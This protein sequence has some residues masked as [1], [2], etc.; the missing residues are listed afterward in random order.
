VGAGVFEYGVTVIHTSVS[1]GETVD[2]GGLFDNSCDGKQSPWTA[3]DMKIG[4]AAVSGLI[5]VVVQNHFLNLQE[6][7]PEQ[8]ILD[9]HV[10]I[11]LRHLKLTVD[12]FCPSVLV[13]THAVDDQVLHPRVL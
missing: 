7:T 2:V 6:A 5:I 9:L 1:D 13:H 8:V 12:I 10:H 3:F 4:S 11:H